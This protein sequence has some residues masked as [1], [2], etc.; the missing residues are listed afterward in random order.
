MKGKLKLGL[1]MTLYCVNETRR[2]GKLLQSQFDVEN[3]WMVIIC[4]DSKSLTAFSL[5]SSKALLKSCLDFMLS[6]ISW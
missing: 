4:F 2:K 6:P 5:S 1:I 3:G